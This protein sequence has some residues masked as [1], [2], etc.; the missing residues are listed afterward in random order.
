MLKAR[1]ALID[2]DN[3]SDSLKAMSADNAREIMEWSGQWWV[4]AIR[5]HVSI[6]GPPRS[7]PSE[8]PRIDTGQFHDGMEYSTFVEAGA[9]TYGYTLIFSSDP[10]SAQVDEIR[11]TFQRAAE[12]DWELF[13]K[14]L[15][16]Y[17]GS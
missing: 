17:T 8:Y 7:L 1:A 6:V 15:D 10:K 2:I 14:E 13:E 12:E 3:L 16:Y 4:D 11:P 9:S 5:H